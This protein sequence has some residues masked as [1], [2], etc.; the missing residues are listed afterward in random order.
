MQSRES[1]STMIING[2]DVS[3]FTMGTN[4]FTVSGS[5]LRIT[6]MRIN[7]LGESRFTMR[8]SGV[9]GRGVHLN[10]LSCTQAIL[11][12]YLVQYRFLATMRQITST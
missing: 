6:T 1:E 8:R 12:I 5:T 3:G 11:N 2:L 7:G 9:G 10:Y 4:G